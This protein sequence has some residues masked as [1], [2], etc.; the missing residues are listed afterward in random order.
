MGGRWVAVDPAFRQAP[1]RGPRF[2]VAT[3]APGDEAARAEAGRR[4][5]ACWGRGG[6][7]PARP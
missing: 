7:E 5:L 1:A 6:V 4:L 2:T 3:W